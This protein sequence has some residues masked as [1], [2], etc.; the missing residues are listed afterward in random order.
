MY[1]FLLLILSRSRLRS[2]VAGGVDY[3]KDCLWCIFVGGLFFDS[4]LGR[5]GVFFTFFPSTRHCWEI[6]TYARARLSIIPYPPYVISSSRLH[7]LTPTLGSICATSRIKKPIHHS[8][9]PPIAYAAPLRSS[10]MPR[11]I[12]SLASGTV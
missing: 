1:F 2:G 9:P 7:P 4:F 6:N 12:A 11:R 5:R 8:P 10:I 3:K